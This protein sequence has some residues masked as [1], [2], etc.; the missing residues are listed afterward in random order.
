MLAFELFPY[1]KTRK[2]KCIKRSKFYF[3]DVGVANKLC[4]REKILPKSIE[5][6]KAFEHFIIQEIRALNSYLEMNWSLSYWRSISKHEV[7]LILSDEMAIE[8][9]ST[10]NITSKHLKSLKLLKEENL[11]KRF[12]IVSNEPVKRMLDGIEIYPWKVFLQE[13]WNLKP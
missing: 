2:R 8:I 12:I 13:L 4:H 1:Q 9:K 10:H 11:I 5:Y 6:G 3:F 7:D